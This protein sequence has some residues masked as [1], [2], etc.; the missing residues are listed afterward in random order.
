MLFSAPL[1][2][3]MKKHSHS[4]MKAWAFDHQHPKAYTK[5]AK[6]SK[7]KM[8]SFL[9]L[10]PHDQQFSV[11]R[12]NN[13]IYLAS[14]KQHAQKPN[15]AIIITST[16]NQKKKVVSWIIFSYKFSFQLLPAS[17]DQLLEQHHEQNFRCPSH[18][19][20]F[21]YT[22]RFFTFFLQ[23]QKLYWADS[24]WGNKKKNGILKRDL[25]LQRRYKCKS[26][27]LLKG[28]EA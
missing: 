22:H 27:S 16:L 7:I 14:R 8:R 13:I 24:I 3:L 5:S 1:W 2:L 11:K 21:W 19:A 17:A 25:N 18:D 23:F 9:H 12:K 26:E 20:V 6:A 15:E 10:S 28:L 4:L